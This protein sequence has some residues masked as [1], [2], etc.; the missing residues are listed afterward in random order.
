MHTTAIK[1]S[2]F[3]EIPVDARFLWPC[4]LAVRDGLKM[5]TED[6]VR[7]RHFPWHDLTKDLYGPKYTQE[8]GLKKTEPGDSEN[9]FTFHYSPGML[10]ELHGARVPV[11]EYAEFFHALHKLDQ[12]SLKIALNVAEAFDAANRLDGKYPGSMVEKLK[13]GTRVIRALRYRNKNDDLPDAK[14][15]VDRSHFTIHTWSSHSGLKMVRPDGSLAP[16]NETAVDMVAVFPGEKFAAVTRGALG[17]GTPHGV[18]DERR[19]NGTRDEDRYAIVCFVHPGPDQ[20]DA[21]WL[22][23]NRDRIEQLEATL[24]I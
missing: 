19:Q 14:P 10:S 22:L 8:V 6:P 5:I 21:D 4:I 20:D 7:Q 12:W 23:N 17:F 2:G 1:R 13:S 9:K 16:V 24:A 3:L 15:H 18:R 11:K